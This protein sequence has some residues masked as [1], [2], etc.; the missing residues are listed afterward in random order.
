MVETGYPML[1]ALRRLG[2]AT[3][4]VTYLLA[5]TRD[6]GARDMQATISPGNHASLALIR[7]FGCEHD[8][9]QGTSSKALS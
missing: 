9:E 3:A 1:A 6:S 7:P 2:L 4:A 5:F 8:G